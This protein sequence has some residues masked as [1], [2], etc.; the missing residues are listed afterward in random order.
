MTD[1]LSPA[2][3]S[4]FLA[5]ERTRAMVAAQRRHRVA[6]EQ[7]QE[8][9]SDLVEAWHNDPDEPEDGRED[10]AIAVTL[11][12]ETAFKTMT[13]L[14]PFLSV[15]ESVTVPDGVDMVVVDLDSGDVTLT[16][17]GLM[18]D[19]SQWCRFPHRNL[20]YVERWSPKGRQFHGWIS[21]EYRTLVQSG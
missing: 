13:E 9:W 15:G 2:K 14:L 1:L 10:Y 21:T 6:I 18:A 11:A 17:D 5:M 4:T 12:E 16:Q 3:S 8:R 7:A 19:T 20:T